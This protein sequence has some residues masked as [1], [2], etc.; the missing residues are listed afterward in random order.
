MVWIL[1]QMGT[2]EDLV[3]P[4]F[5]YPVQRHRGSQCFFLVKI[6]LQIFLFVF[7]FF[8]VKAGQLWPLLLLAGQT[9]GAHG[10]HALPTRYE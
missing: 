2:F 6:L 1:F 10:G 4:R 5:L 7:G 9:D 3:L 8:V